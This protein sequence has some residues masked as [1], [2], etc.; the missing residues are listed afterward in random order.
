LR[1]SG[2]A[3]PMTM[4]AK[5]SAN[6]RLCASPRATASNSK[7]ITTTIDKLSSRIDSSKPAVVG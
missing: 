2:S 3:P 7:S 5:P 1:A 6:Q 4:G